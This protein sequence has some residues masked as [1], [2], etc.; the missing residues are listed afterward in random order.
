MASVSGYFV[1]ATKP[2]G[3]PGAEGW[4]DR[5]SSSESNVVRRICLPQPECDETPEAPVVQL[6]QF[7]LRVVKNPCTVFTASEKKELCN[8]MVRGTEGF[9]R[10]PRRLPGW[11]FHYFP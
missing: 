10:R 7:M 11:I 1:Q 4:L 6:Y 3:F 8:L 9:R 2:R 5:R